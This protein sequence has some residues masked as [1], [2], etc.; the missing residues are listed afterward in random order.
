MIKLGLMQRNIIVIG[1]VLVLVGL[2]V[3]GYRWYKSSANT[4]SVTANSLTYNCEQGKNALEL[5]DLYTDNLEIRD[6][7]FGKQII[8]IN[9]V[10]QGG[11]KFWLYTIDGREATT[12][13]DSYYCQDEEVV[14][15]Q[16]K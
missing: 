8:A 5:L 11:G 3:G 14:E 13:A 4:S 15:W 16:L 6:F 10:S 7:S 12:S 2:S 9:G 1:I